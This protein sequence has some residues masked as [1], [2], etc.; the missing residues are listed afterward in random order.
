M[1]SVACDALKWSENRANW[2]STQAGKGTAEA[3]IAVSDW[4][5]GR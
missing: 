1:A 4:L 2:C 3:Q 5:W